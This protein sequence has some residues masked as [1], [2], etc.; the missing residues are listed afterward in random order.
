[1]LKIVSPVIITEGNSILSCDISPEDAAASMESIAVTH[2]TPPYIAYDAEGRL[3]RIET[4][5]KKGH[6]SPSSPNINDRWVR[7]VSAEENP[8]CRE[9]L[10][11]LIREH[12][13][14]NWELGIQ[15]NETLD[16]LVA[17]LFKMHSENKKMD[18]MALPILALEQKKIH[19][20]RTLRQV[21]TCLNTK[22]ASKNAYEIYDA[23]GTTL[24]PAIVA[25]QKYLEKIFNKKNNFIEKMAC[26]FTKSNIPEELVILS[27]APQVTKTKLDLKKI[28][29][30]RIK[31]NGWE[32]NDLATLINMYAWISLNPRRAKKNG[33]TLAN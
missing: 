5:D 31:K 33:F 6:V 1:M 2:G 30:E 13:N 10:I 21:A 29:K 12:L 19:V 18:G 3:L 24:S 26:F 15:E 16:N 8:N 20:F 11:N 25:K 14:E 28:L 4:V 7:I 23:F 32:S 9:L 17:I 22:K 27:P